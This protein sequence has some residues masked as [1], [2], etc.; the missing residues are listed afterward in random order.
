M[1]IG[2]PKCARK[3]RSAAKN[4]VEEERDFTIGLL[5][6]DATNFK[7]ATTQFLNAPWGTFHLSA[8]SVM[9]EA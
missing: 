7:Q 5:L 6:R 8:V 2:Q 3:F 9:L 1:G 4:S